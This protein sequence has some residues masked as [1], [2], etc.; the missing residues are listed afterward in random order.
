MLHWRAHLFL[1]VPM[2][3]IY[4][5]QCKIVFN[6]HFKANVIKIYFG[7]HSTTLEYA[8]NLVHFLLIITSVRVPCQDLARRL[9]SDKAE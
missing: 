2:Y 3:S 9:V 6:I 8:K 1:L 5:V 4:T 7:L